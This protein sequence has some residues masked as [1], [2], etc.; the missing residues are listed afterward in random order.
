MEWVILVDH[1][2]KRNNTCLFELLFKSLSWTGIELMKSDGADVSSLILSHL[3][4]YAYHEI[5]MKYFCVSEKI[6]FVSF[7]LLSTMLF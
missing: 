2:Q 1:A 3:M 4:K 7:A 5:H 6:G